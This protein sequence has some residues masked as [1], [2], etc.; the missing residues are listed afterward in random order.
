VDRN[1]D[2]T[3]RTDDGVER[4]A[5]SLRQ[6]ASRADDLIEAVR[7]E[8]GER[9]HA[10]IRR[11]E[12]QLRRTQADLDELEESMRRRARSAVRAVDR[13]AHDHPYAAAGG[14][15]LLGAAIGVLIGIA[16]ARR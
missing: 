11:L 3:R 16:L 13:A 8:G 14:S 12:R 2:M 6:I 4:L 5:A 9:Y 15:A 10:S 7:K 1:D